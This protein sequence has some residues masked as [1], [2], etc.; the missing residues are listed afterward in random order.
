MKFFLSLSLSILF[1]SNCFSQGL[2]LATK[3]DLAQFKSFSNETFG[4]AESLPS[5]YSLE[6]YVPPIQQQVGQTCV[7]WASLYYALSTMYNQK[8]NISLHTLSIML[9]TL[10]SYTQ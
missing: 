5:K 3:E 9:L 1:V 6:K 2:N 10:I 7:G 4:F 8:F